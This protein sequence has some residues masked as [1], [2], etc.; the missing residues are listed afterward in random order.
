M[1]HVISIAGVSFE[2]L[3]TL[4]IYQSDLDPHNYPVEFDERFN[5][6]ARSLFGE[7]PDFV[8]EGHRSFNASMKAYTVQ[9]IIK[10]S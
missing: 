3:S 1:R 8:Q 7:V 10:R 5:A 4:P 6:E 9:G 2:H